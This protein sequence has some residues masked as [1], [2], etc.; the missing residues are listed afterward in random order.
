VDYQIFQFINN[1]AGHYR[2]LDWLGVFFASYFQYFLGAGL[3]IYMLRRGDKIERLKNFKLTLFFFAAAVVSRFVFG[4][5]IKRI[6]KRSRPFVT[7][8]V[9]QLIS[10]DLNLSFPSGHAVF[11][12][13][14]SS[15]VYFYNKKAGIVCFVGS[16]LMGLARIFTGVHYPSDIIGGAA[17]GIL[18][19]W[20][21]GK[22]FGKKVDGLITNIRQS[23]K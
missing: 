18:I 10:E 1:F 20:L 12:F 2:W 16:C 5:I 23:V 6:V 14:L 3:V 17:L 21:V 19:G 9:V 15:V 13:S 7:H 22:I 8:R 4:E 11:F